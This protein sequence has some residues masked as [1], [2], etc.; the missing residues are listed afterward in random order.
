MLACRP[1]CLEIKYVEP[2]DGVV[3]RLKWRLYPFKNDQPLGACRDRCAMSDA[4]EPYKV[5][6]KSWYLLGRDRHVCDIPL[7]HPSCSKQHA[8]LQ[9][10]LIRHEVRSACTVGTA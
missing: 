8:V 5:H 10:R 9:Y 7:D 6:R 4:L 3:P 1:Q 2:E